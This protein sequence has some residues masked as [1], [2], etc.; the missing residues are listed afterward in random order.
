MI[1]IANSLHSIIISE[2]AVHTQ[3]LI[4]TTPGQDVQLLIEPYFPDQIDQASLNDLSS[5]K[6]VHSGTVS[7]P[8]EAG[9]GGF[10]R[11]AQSVILLDLVPA[12]MQMPDLAERLV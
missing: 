10:G 6:E 11:F 2:V 1:V 3:P 9:V 4:T 8:S 12:A 5:V 7:S